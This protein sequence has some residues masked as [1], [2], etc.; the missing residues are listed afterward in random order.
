M[1][2]IPSK[3]NFYFIEDDELYF[4]GEWTGTNHI[5]LTI[6]EPKYGDMSRKINLGTMQKYIHEITY[7]KITYDIAII[8][9]NGNVFM[10]GQT[11][12]LNDSAELSHKIKFNDWTKIKFPQ[13]ISQIHHD[14]FNR[15]IID[16][17][18]KL[19]FYGKI[20]YSDAESEYIFDDIREVQ[21]DDEIIDMNL[22]YNFVITNK[23]QLLHIY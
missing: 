14:A 11:I 19:Y 7:I 6:S 8:I 13:Q 2:I 12:V 21:C 20:V 10:N 5:S 15:A 22:Y 16:Q 1:I 17:Y 9:V 23:N 3:Y 18:G 4:F